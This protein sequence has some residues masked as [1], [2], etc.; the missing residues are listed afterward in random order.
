M[1]NQDKKAFNPADLATV[2][3]VTIPLLKKE[4]NT[5]IY[6]VITGAIF[7]GKDMPAAEGKAQMEPAHIA[8]VIDLSTGEVMET[9]CNSVM[10]SSL[11]EEYPNEGYINKAFKIV[12]VKVEGKRYKNYSIAE[13][14]NPLAKD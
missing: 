1:A 5:P 14:E 7:K 3:L 12:Q 11:E 4:D 2:K 8:R 13:I 6:V 10:K 9:I